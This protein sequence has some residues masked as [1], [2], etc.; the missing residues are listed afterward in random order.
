MI[1]VWGTRNIRRHRGYVADF[2]AVC[3]AIRPFQVSDIKLAHHFFFVPITAGTTTGQMRTCTVCGQQAFPEPDTYTDF[4]DD[5]H[6]DID[7]LV[8]RTNP[9]LFDDQTDRMLLEEKL[10]QFP[11]QITA[12]ER[13]A[14][15]VEPF[16]ALSGQVERRFAPGGCANVLGS[17]ALVVALFLACLWIVYS[18][19]TTGGMYALVTA[20]G[21][22][23]ALL[24]IY[25]LWTF[26]TSS[27]RYMNGRVVPLLARALVPLKPTESELTEI[28]ATLKADGHKI[29]KKL[30]ARWIMNELDSAD[31]RANQS[32][33]AAEE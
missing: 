17:L 22:V 26:A 2:C 5:A 24:L 3:R 20:G 4:V 1:L 32:S 12:G 10:K 14:L 16:M 31:I 15:L 25:A 33:Y 19:E 7:T 21:V 28:L 11:D 8:Q 27:R 9:T 18:D 30:K 23:G 13:T 6:A 29:A